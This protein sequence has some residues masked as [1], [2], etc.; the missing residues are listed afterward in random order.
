MNKTN[1]SLTSLLILKKS[2]T[3]R[4]ENNNNI[5]KKIIYRGFNFEV[6]RLT[7]SWY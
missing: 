7:K 5:I 4:H 6:Q 2:K 1:S 3:A